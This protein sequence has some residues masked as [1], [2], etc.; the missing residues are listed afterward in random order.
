MAV[1]IEDFVGY[2]RS[3]VYESMTNEGFEATVLMLRSFAREDNVTPYGDMV[4]A[5][6]LTMY[7]ELE[8][9]YMLQERRKLS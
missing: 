8:E 7:S 2:Y 4:R 1:N 3:E 5:I 6:E 9:Q